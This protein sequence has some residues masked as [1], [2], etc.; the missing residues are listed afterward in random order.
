MGY[1]GTL[2]TSDG[3]FEISDKFISKYKDRYNFGRGNSL[4]ISSKFEVKRFYDDLEDDIIEELKLQKNT[5][6][7]R[8]EIQAVWLY[9]DGLVDRI[10]FTENGVIP[11]PVWLKKRKKDGYID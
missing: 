6:W 10:V 3:K 5:D 9:E 11:Y 2:I 7:F 4:P 8:K 1:R